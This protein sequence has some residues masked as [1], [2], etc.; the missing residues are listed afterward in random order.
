MIDVII[1]GS[2]EVKKAELLRIEKTEKGAVTGVVRFQ[3]GA[4]MY[5]IAAEGS[6]Q[7]VTG[8]SNDWIAEESQPI[9]K[10]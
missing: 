3:D 10:Q 5:A 9:A 7:W 4:T 2:R 1:M 6:D 8:T